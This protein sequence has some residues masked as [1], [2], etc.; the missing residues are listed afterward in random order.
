[1]SSTKNDP[2]GDSRV[3]TMAEHIGSF[4]EYWGFKEVHGK[5]WTLIFLSPEPIDAN[6]LKESLKLSKALI[7]M[8]IKDLLH[9]RV[10][11]EVEKDK[12]GTQKY[13]I[14]T[15]ITNVILDVLRQRELKMLV[16][17]QA[18]FQ[19]LSSAHSKKNLPQVDTLRLGELGVMVDT[20]K[21]ILEAMTQ[22]SKVDFQMFET[23]MT[24]SDPCQ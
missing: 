15:D 6:Y 22:G 2:C 12:P 17:I 9:Y 5:V 14:N 1:M 23:V 20:A 24:L 3:L 13:K 8:T 21:S 18:A 11:L 7:S 4:I 16:E 19:L 10:I